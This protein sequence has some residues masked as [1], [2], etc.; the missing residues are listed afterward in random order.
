MAE[1]SPAGTASPVVA[2]I[3][4]TAASPVDLPAGSIT[5]SALITAVCGKGEKI[6][7]SIFYLNILPMHIV[8]FANKNVLVYH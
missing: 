5:A 7:L 3:S 8:E 4:P 1:A 2:V 6:L